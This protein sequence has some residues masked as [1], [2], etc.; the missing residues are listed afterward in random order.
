[1]GVGRSE[2]GPA[3]ASNVE[4]HARLANRRVCAPQYTEPR[5]NWQNAKFQ[6]KK[7]ERLGYS[8]V[9]ARNRNVEQRVSYYYYPTTTTSS[10]WPYAM[11]EGK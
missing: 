6:L 11:R 1:M 8:D 9:S 3:T 10:C 5:G 2:Q 4:P 7:S